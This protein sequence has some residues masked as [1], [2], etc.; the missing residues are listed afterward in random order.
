MRK[1]GHKLCG[2]KLSLEN[3]VPPNGGYAQDGRSSGY[4]FLGVDKYIFDWFRPQKRA[5]SDHEIRGMFVSHGHQP[6]QSFKELYHFGWDVWKDDKDYW[7]RKEKGVKWN[8]HKYSSVDFIYENLE[9]YLE[10]QKKH[11]LQK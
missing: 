11:E 4:W 1:T 10:N 5:L 2:F 7:K 9:K 6:Y 8:F 3:Y